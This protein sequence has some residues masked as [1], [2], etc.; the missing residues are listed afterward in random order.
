MQIML[1][2]AAVESILFYGK[3]PGSWGKGRKMLKS[4]KW[5]SSATI[6]KTQNDDSNISVWNKSQ[7]NGT[8]N[9]EFTK[10]GDFLY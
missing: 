2:Y 1:F 8:M 5:V 4:Q 6:E 10:Y 7:H 9:T 3:L